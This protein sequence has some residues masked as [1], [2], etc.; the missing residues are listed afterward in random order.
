M[1]GVRQ[2]G[3]DGEN[4]SSIDQSAK[5]RIPSATG[6]AAYR[7][8]DALTETTLTEVKNVA[9]LSKTSQLSDFL[10]YSSSTGRSFNL[11][12]R[13]STRLT[14]PLQELVESG[15]INLLRTLPSL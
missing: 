9:T 6:T 7:I 10:Q 15:A 14:A 4:L 13:E 2:T 8:P 3:A 5:V 1:A 12:V 11:V